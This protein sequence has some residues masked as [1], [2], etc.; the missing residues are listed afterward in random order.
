MTSGSLTMFAPL[1]VDDYEASGW[2]VLAVGRAETADDADMTLK[3][4]AAHL[5]PYVEGA[6]TALVRIE[7]TFISGRR[8]VHASQSNGCWSP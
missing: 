5:E 4:K 3:V 7:P 8:P 6:R 2:S 1:E